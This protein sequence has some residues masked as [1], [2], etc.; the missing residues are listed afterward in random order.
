MRQRNRFSAVYETRRPNSKI[1][2]PSRSFNQLPVNVA[3]LWPLALA[4]SPGLTDFRMT[5]ADQ[6]PINV[7]TIRNLD[8]FAE[9]RYARPESS[10]DGEEQ[11]MR[12]P[13]TWVPTRDSFYGNYFRFIFYK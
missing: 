6:L 7:V 10:V 8:A 9:Q 1:E 13:A 5:V 11:N 2:R 12:N 3:N 4:R